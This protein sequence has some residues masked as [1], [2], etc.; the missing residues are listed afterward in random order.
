[1]GE[2]F[3]S[4]SRKYNH[5]HGSWISDLIGLISIINVLCMNR[6]SYICMYTRLI[7]CS[8]SREYILIQLQR[9]E[10]LIHFAYAPK[11]LHLLQRHN[12]RN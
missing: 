6:T 9:R 3:Q 7:H 2:R 10:H 11:A 4:H 5:L 12:E 8:I 1:M